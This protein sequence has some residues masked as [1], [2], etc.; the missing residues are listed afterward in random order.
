MENLQTILKVKEEVSEK[1]V[2]SLSKTKFH[3]TVYSNQ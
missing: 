3:D 2:L 1:A